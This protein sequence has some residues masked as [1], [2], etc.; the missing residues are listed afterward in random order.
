MALREAIHTVLALAVLILFTG[1]TA[2]DGSQLNSTFTTVATA[3]TIPGAAGPNGE[4][5]SV[6]P[7]VKAV[8]GGGGDDSD[9]FTVPGLTIDEEGAKEEAG[10][11]EHSLNTGKALST[12]GTS[13]GP[14]S[15]RTCSRP[16]PR[17]SEKA[18][19]PSAPGR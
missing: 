7:V 4:G 19:E 14:P 18:G 10:E 1:V 2:A 3:V 11:K 9:V 5:K 8:L 17:R 15:S 12:V 16:S 13:A 6:G